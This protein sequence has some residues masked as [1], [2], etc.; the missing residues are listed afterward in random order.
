MQGCQA[1]YSTAGVCMLEQPLTHRCRLFGAWPEFCLKIDWR[2]QLTL[3]SKTFFHDKDPGRNYPPLIQFL[4]KKH[5]LHIVRKAMSASE[6]YLTRLPLEI[7][8]Q[9]CREI[10]IE[11]VSLATDSSTMIAIILQLNKFTTS[12][13]KI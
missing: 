10:L 12:P 8:H 3:R 13:Q 6:S 5:P 1:K 9:Y 11:D 7:L 4:K 2:L